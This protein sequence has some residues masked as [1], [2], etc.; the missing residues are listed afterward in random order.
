MLRQLF[1]K[2]QTRVAVNLLLYGR[3]EWK[4]RLSWFGTKVG[5]R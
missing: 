5:K 3:Q 2:L 1:P 4:L